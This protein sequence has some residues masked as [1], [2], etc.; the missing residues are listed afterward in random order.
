M[1][2][3]LIPDEAVALCH[4][5][6]DADSS[7]GDPLAV[8]I[9]YL[10]Q[11]KG[12]QRPEPEVIGKAASPQERLTKSIIAGASSDLSKLIDDLLGSMPPKEIIDRILLP[13][14]QEVGQRFGRGEMALPFVLAS[15]E[16]M[17][18][19]IDLVAPHMEVKEEI[20]KG[21]IVLATVRG[22][23]HD[24]GKNLVDVILSNN[25]FNVINLGIRQPAVAIMEA[26]REQGAGAIGLS[27]LLV[28]STEV[29]RQDLVT[30]RDGGIDVPVLCGGAALT[31]SF[32]RDTLAPAYGSRVHY[33]ADAFAALTAM[34][35]IAKR[36]E[37]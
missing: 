37:A 1:P 13:T 16:T 35:G 24:I 27:G 8:F 3:H 18:R 20:Q 7:G 30:F 32:V 21:T 34:E 31:P 11:M 12:E 2:L 14:M 10:K 19:A 36:L 23:V 17:R 4:R 6:I 5:L 9:D 29:M 33:C 22:D 25:G 15:A 26:V 28:S